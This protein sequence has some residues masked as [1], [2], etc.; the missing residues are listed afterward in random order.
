MKNLFVC[1][2]CNTEDKLV[3][4][5]ES[6][7]VVCTTCGTVIVGQIQDPRR[8]LD[9]NAVSGLGIVS[10]SGPHSSLATHDMNLS[11]FI[12]KSNRDSSGRIINSN[13]LAKMTKLRA[14][15]TRTQLA[16]SSARNFRIA[17]SLLNK[18]RDKLSVPYCVV[19]STAY[20]YRKIEH[21]GLVR[22]RTISSVLAAC[23]YLTCREMGVPRTMAEIQKA[24]NVKKK[25]I[26]RDYREIVQS[27]E[28]YVPPVNYFQC[29]EKISNNLELDGKITRKGMKLMQSI[30]EVEIEISAGKDPM[31]LA[32]SVL[33]IILQ[34]E[35]QTIR[36]AKI[37]NAAGVSEVTLRARTRGIKN[38]LALIC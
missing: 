14:W 6:G 3:T 2:T 5:L 34:T 11:T 33:Y 21:R 7:E 26:A 24:S 16:D 27:L 25:Q 37:A 36:Q 30:V 8:E 31:G 20:T 29:L 9:Q 1:S 15:D 4:D 28:L 17:F 23:L 22:G 18:L 32:A 12:G 10:G 19:E 13:T 38:K 35:G